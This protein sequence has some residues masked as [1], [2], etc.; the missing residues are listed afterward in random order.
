MSLY[1]ELLDSLPFD[2]TERDGLWGYRR[3]DEP[4][5]ARQAFALGATLAL[6]LATGLGI[7]PH[8]DWGAALF[9]GLITAVFTRGLLLARHRLLN[10]GWRAWRQRN[11]NVRALDLVSGG[12]GAVIALMLATGGGGIGPAFAP[13]QALF[14]GILAVIASRAILLVAKWP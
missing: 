3:A 6:C 2:P 9:F 11:P 5:V 13:G 14:I 12:L 7:A 10:G 8:I 4:T 1:R